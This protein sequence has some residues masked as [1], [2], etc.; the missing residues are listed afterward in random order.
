MQLNDKIIAYRLINRQSDDD[1]NVQLIQK[2]IS[3]PVKAYLESPFFYLA[4]MLCKS[5]TFIQDKERKDENF[6]RYD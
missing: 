5:F 6:L 1:Q 4:L 3:M 2:Y